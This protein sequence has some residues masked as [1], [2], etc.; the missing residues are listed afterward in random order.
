MNMFRVNSKIKNNLKFFKYY[1]VFTNIY[2]IFVSDLTTLVNSSTNC[3]MEKDD[4]KKITQLTKEY[5]EL[6]LILEGGD[7]TKKITFDC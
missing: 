2:C 3:S 1:F 6:M 5:Q 4:K 7:K